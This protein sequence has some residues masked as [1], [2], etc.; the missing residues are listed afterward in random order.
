[1]HKAYV[2]VLLEKKNLYTK[3]RQYL[4]ARLLSS[5]SSY[6]FYCLIFSGLEK[7]VIKNF[8][9]LYSSDLFHELFCKFH[10]I[11]LIYPLLTAS[12]QP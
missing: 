1:M 8:F 5:L 11:N 9:Q 7:K 6:P 3:Y 4:F 10:S 2:D 12:K